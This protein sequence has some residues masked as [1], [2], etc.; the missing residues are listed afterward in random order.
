MAPSCAS[1]VGFV[2]I[3]SERDIITFVNLMQKCWAEKPEDRP[4]FASVLEILYQLESETA[5]R[6]R[7][8]RSQSEVLEKKALK[9]AST[10]STSTDTTATSPLGTVRMMEEVLLEA[11]EAG[12]GNIEN[13]VQG[14]GGGEGD[15]K[16]KADGAE[17]N[18]EAQVAEGTGH[19]RRGTEQG[20]AGSLLMEVL[21]GRG[22]G[23]SKLV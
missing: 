11:K 4:D 13:N 22:R 8:Q 10:I 2:S 17:E 12:S 20:L 9:R 3:A 6:M 15:S 21:S 16:S 1:M 5:T 23:S 14:E 19:L 7:K 18:S